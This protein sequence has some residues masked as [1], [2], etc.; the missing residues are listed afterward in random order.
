MTLE[1][2]TIGD[3]ILSGNIV[4]TNT[5]YLSDKL[6]LNGFEV[7]YHSA[8]RD[9]EEKIREAL[10]LAASRSQT[11]IVTGGLGPTADDFTIEV[12]A[13]TFGKKLVVDEKA[14]KQLNNLFKQWGRPLKENNKK[15]AMVPQGAHTYMNRVG[16]APGVG[17]TYK[18]AQLYFLPGVPKEMKQIFEDFILPE[19]ISS[20]KEKVF[21]ESLFLKCFGSAE[22]DLDYALKSL[23]VN[24]TEIE[25]ARI[26]FRAHFPE[27]FIKISAWH[28][29]ANEAKKILKD[30]EQKIRNEVGQYVYGQGEDTL[31]SVVGSLLSQSK[32]TIALAE[33]CTG[34]LVCHRLTNIPG[35][36]TYLKNGVV[37]YSNES[38]ISVLGVSADTLKKKGSV[39]S[40]CALEM[41][42]GIRRISK[43]DYGLAITGIAGPD[44]GTPSKP[45]GTVHVALVGGQKDW[46][47][48]FFFPRN[49][50]WFKLLVSSIA[51][52]KLRKE[53]LGDNEVERIGSSKSH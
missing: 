12:A 46:E 9:D 27:I 47:K 19:I 4:D 3:E 1:I 14:L 5:A 51:L 15:Q 22:S 20:R 21:F 8:V 26:G 17:L 10:L 34:G 49:R 24:R 18:G 42:H 52:D 25:N 32:K 28:K 13:K 50:E 45:V 31:E 36:S 44:G 41:A 23:Y 48:K 38:K 16:T 37:C 53:L 6:W 11:I 7:N 2:L 35:A 33:S 30:V 43:T 39:S 29:K 40:E